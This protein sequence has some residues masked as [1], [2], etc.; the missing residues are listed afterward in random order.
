MAKK[1][2]EEIRRE[3]ELKIEQTFN[4]VTPLIEDK[5][6]VEQ[7]KEGSTLKKIYDIVMQYM[8]QGP[9]NPCIQIY[10]HFKVHPLRKEDSSLTTTIK[11]RLHVL[12]NIEVDLM[13]QKQSTPA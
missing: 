1:S 8:Y 10:K 2:P 5:K 7:L 9:K 11:N 6:K 12:R 4:E 13:L 3:K